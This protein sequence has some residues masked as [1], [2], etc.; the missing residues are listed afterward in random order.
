[1]ALPED[2]LFPQ[3]YIRSP[4]LTPFEN[5]EGAKVFWLILKIDEHARA[6]AA[7]REQLPGLKGEDKEKLQAAIDGHTA[8]ID[9]AKGEQQTLAGTD[10]A[11]KRALVKANVE[12]WIRNLRSRVLDFKRYER[13][14]RKLAGD[15]NNKQDR[16][17]HE[18]NAQADR[19]EADRYDRMAAEL[20]YDLHQAGL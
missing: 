1:M 19:D 20:D 12:R 8:A 15:A 14:E 17:R 4:R 10:A 13:E 3:D 9:Q 11:A 18:G 5:L 16:D 6:R 2:D 7:D